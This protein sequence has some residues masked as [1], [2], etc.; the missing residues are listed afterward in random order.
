MLGIFTLSFSQKK[1]YLV[2]RLWIE[3]VLVF[4]IF[5]KDVNCF[6]AERIVLDI[7]RVKGQFVKSFQNICPSTIYILIT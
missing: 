4:R 5:A 1:N 3:K 6:K 7:S 2:K